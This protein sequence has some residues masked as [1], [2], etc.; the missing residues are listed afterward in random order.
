M[1][2]FFKNALENFQVLKPFCFEDILSFILH[3]EFLQI[4]PFRRLQASFLL[5]L[6]VQRFLDVCTKFLLY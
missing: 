1:V 3:G 2:V 4:T 5:G 6:N